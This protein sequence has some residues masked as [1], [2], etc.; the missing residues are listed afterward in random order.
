MAQINENFI[1]WFHANVDGKNRSEYF[2]ADIFDPIKVCTWMER[3]F[4]AGAWMNAND[5]LNQLEHWAA[6]AHD[7]LKVVESGTF[8]LEDVYIT[9]SVDLGSWYEEKF[10]H[11]ES[12]FPANSTK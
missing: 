9:T 2:Y 11:H 4:L 10:Q 1:G 12:Q 7:E 3:A 5:T 8:N 6:Q